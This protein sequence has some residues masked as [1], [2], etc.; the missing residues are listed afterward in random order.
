MSFV[1]AALRLE[2]ARLYWTGTTVYGWL[3][4][5]W[6]CFFTRIL[7]WYLFFGKDCGHIL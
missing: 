4:V 6:R 3:V 5:R 7:G 2:P 1:A